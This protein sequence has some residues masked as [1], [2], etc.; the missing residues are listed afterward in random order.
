VYDVSCQTWANGLA[1]SKLSE[2]VGCKLPAMD[3]CYYDMVNNVFDFSS[4]SSQTC[5]NDFGELENTLPFYGEA[6]VLGFPATSHWSDNDRSNDNLQNNILKRMVKAD[7]LEE[8]KDPQVEVIITRNGTQASAKVQ[9]KVTRNETLVKLRKDMAA[10][11]TNKPLVKNILTIFIDALPRAHFLRKLKKTT[12][13]IN[14]FYNND[15]SLME[16]YQFFRYH[17][18]GYYTASTIFPI[19]FG[20]SIHERNG[21]EITKHLEEQGYITG[22]SRDICLSK[23]FSYRDGEFPNITF[24]SPDHENIAMFCD[25]NYHQFPFPTGMFAGPYSLYRRCLYGKD[26]Y[27]YVLEYGAEFWKAYAD[28]PKFLELGFTDQHESTG[29]VV[30]YMDDKLAEFL[31][32]MEQ[33]GLL[34]DT[35]IVFY[36][37]HG[38]HMNLLLYLTNATSMRLE[39]WLP[40]LFIMLPRELADTHG[41]N[42]KDKEQTLVNSFDL[43]NF[44]K[45]VSG[46]TNYAGYGKDLLL[47]DIE[48]NRTCE[49]YYK[50]CMCEAE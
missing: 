6:K 47:H 14:K 35:A 20:T 16:S 27:E 2:L 10:T 38:Q 45:G 30:G 24:D 40:T 7:T 34:N 13:W 1:D 41:K 28:Q 46:L 29:E 44:F 50:E 42:L 11:A 43:H 26:T 25:P 32:D 3:F 49:N 36:A 37:D 19:Y 23:H 12:A 21:I 4:H 31:G 48:E 5:H 33:Q 39:M 22:E 15:E 9:V 18:V 8:I 17:S